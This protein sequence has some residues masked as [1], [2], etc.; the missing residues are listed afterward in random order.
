[1]RECAERAGEYRYI[2]DSLAAFCDVLAEKAE[3]SAELYEA[4]HK[5]KREVLAEIAGERIE[6][7]K[8]LVEEFRLAFRRQWLRESHSFGFDVMDIR[9][10]GVLC[11]LD[12]AQYLISEYLEGR[13]D[14]IDELEAQRLPYGFDGNV[15]SDGET[16]LLNR[17]QRMSGQV[18]SNMFG[19]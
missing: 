8:A 1:M 17:W 18:V 2:Y 3:L 13:I 9:I 11:Q 16:I 5:D 15:K 7:V 19:Y 10:G 14:K 4:Y 12:T 6:T